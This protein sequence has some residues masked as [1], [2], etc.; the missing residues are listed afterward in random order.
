MFC[1]KFQIIVNTTKVK[2]QRQNRM[3]RD[4][5]DFPAWAAQNHLKK[6]VMDALSKEDFCSYDM[7][8][9]LSEE[10]IK[11]ITEKYKL[12]LGM[13]KLLTKSVKKM[14]EKKDDGK[15]GNAGQMSGKSTPQKTNTAIPVT[16]PTTLQVG[17]GRDLITS[18]SDYFI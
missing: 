4:N 7:L 6:E 15:A 16:T 14:Q 13:R 5:F 12:S 2:K 11:E 10:D 17:P 9:L 18:P 8:L 1:L 3:D